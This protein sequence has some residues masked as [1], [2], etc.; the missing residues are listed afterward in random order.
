MGGSV[1]SSKVSANASTSNQS[2]CRNA[3]NC[4]QPHAEW[5]D[6]VNVRSRSSSPQPCHMERPME[7][8]WIPP[9]RLQQPPATPIWAS[10]PGVTAELQ[11]Q[12]HTLGRGVCA[13][14]SAVPGEGSVGE[15]LENLRCSLEEQMGTRRFQELYVALQSVGRKTLNPQASHERV[16]VVADVDD[17]EV[18]R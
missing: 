18:F 7:R 17:A 6:I 13:S 16:N 9:Q 3:G 10:A 1:F 4:P 15:Q 14:R 12:G 2:V 8:R 5:S 11:S